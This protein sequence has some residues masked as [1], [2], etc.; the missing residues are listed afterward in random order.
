MRSC[1]RVNGW[2]KFKVGE[3][4]WPFLSHRVWQSIRIARPE[5]QAHSDV[6]YPAGR[7]H[8]VIYRSWNLSGEGGAFRL[9]RSACLCQCEDGRFIHQARPWL[10]ASVSPNMVRAMGLGKR[11]NR[12]GDVARTESTTTRGASGRQ[13]QAI[14][15]LPFTGPAER[16]EAKPKGESHRRLLSEG[17]CKKSFKGLLSVSR[18]LSTLWIR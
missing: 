12:Q 16:P 10:L 6:P 18:P 11:G 13:R 4:T 14:T 17:N 9:L 1:L 8:P 5:N 7:A 3:Q 15:E 2:R